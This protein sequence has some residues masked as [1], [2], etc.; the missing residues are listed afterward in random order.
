MHMV[1]EAFK[2]KIPTMTD[3]CGYDPYMVAQSTT[4]SFINDMHRY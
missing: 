3:T 2:L 4:E 1:A